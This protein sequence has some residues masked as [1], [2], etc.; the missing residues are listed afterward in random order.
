M[1]YVKDGGNVAG[2]ELY[3]QYSMQ[4]FSRTECEV[5]DTPKHLQGK[6]IPR[7][8]F[9]LELTVVPGLTPPSVEKHKT[10]PGILLQHIDRFPL[11]EVSVHAPRTHWQSSAT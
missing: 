2:D 1:F 8:L 10:I 7:L 9:T 5:Y 11:S 3:L 4:K 6:H